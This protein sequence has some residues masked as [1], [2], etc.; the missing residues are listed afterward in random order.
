MSSFTYGCNWRRQKSLLFDRKEIDSVPQLLAELDELRLN[1]YYFRGQS[2]AKFAIV[3]SIQ[4][5]WRRGGCW[6]CKN[7][8]KSYADFMSGLLEFARK[9]N[10]FSFCKGSLMDHEIWAYLQHF[11][12]PTPLID[13]SSNP[14]VAAFFATEH[15]SDKNGF[16]SIYALESDL[17]ISGNIQDIQR[18]DELLQ[19]TVSREKYYVELAGFVYNIRSI[20]THSLSRFANWGFMENGVIINDKVNPEYPKS[21]PENGFAFL[22]SK[23]G[24]NWCPK[25]TSG[26]MNLQEGLFVYAP[27]AD[28]SLEEFFKRKLDKTDEQGNTQSVIYQ[29]MKCFDIPASNVKELRQAVEGAN[30]S[31]DSLGLSPCEQ[32]NGVK[33]MYGEYLN[34]LAA[35]AQTP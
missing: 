19:N 14:F 11:A 8:T 20:R 27:I 26:R 32:E 31:R 9:S 29:K 22:I 25:I 30:I 35:T 23:D 2:N 24:N 15:A 6:K 18:L 4:R 12:C 3:S 7:P 5:A 10:L 1:N 34:R 21:L 16:C 13:F 33:A 17:S 28:E